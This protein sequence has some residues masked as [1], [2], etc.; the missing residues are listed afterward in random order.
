M[1]PTKTFTLA[2]PR[3]FDGDPFE[4]AARSVA[5]AL[6]LLALCHKAL[7]GASL[8]ARNA[9]L[10]RQAQRKEDLDPAAWE[11]GPQAA[12][13][14]AARA[15]IFRITNELAPVQAAAGYDPKNPPKA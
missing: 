4:V 15:D 13:L 9:E 10:E 1:Y 7:E 5:Q 12:R 6:A 14:K 2:D 3:S 8:M 11:S